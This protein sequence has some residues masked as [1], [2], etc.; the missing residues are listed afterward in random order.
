MQY[1][2]LEGKAV[3][4]FFL[5]TQLRAIPFILFFEFLSPLNV[6]IVHRD[7]FINFLGQ[8]DFLNVGF[9]STLRSRKVGDDTTTKVNLETQIIPLLNEDISFNTII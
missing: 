9:D 8:Y 3:M 2:K 4:D 1:Q 6:K 5:K 7:F